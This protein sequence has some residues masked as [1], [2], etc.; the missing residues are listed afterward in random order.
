[1]REWFTSDLHFGHRAVAGYRGFLGPE[2]EPDYP[3]HDAV[4]IARWNKAV[5]PADTVWVLGDLALIEPCYIWDRVD[6]LNG[7][8]HLIWGNHDSGSPIHRDGW[9][10]QREY[11]EHF[12]TAQSFARRRMEGH[13]VYISH[14][15]WRG[16]GD[17]TTTERYDQYRLS[18]PPCEPC[19]RQGAPHPAWLIHGHVHDKWQRKG[20]M[21]NMGLDVWDMTPVPIDT[22]MKMIREY[23]MA[24][25]AA[26]EHMR[27]SQELGD[28]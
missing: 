13:D 6:Q 3:T 27:L 16:A 18:Q 12:A 8:K 25:A 20:R 26:D 9:K 10:Y 11:L 28:D 19:K 15:P 4:I 2:G 22:I 14:F 7:V 21:I 5:A 23:D 17:H 1:M 24:A